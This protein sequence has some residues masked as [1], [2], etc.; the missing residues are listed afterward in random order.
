MVCDMIEEEIESYI[1]EQLETAYPDVDAAQIIISFPEIVMDYEDRRRRG[2]I[3]IDIFKVA[4]TIAAESMIDR[5][6]FIR[7]FP[8]QI[9]NIGSQNLLQK[10]LKCARKDYAEAVNMKAIIFFIEYKQ[11]V[12][13]E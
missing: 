11:E 7:A 6:P 1:L 12:R 2:V 8:H 3:G 4:V 9:V 10:Y 13:K 5:L